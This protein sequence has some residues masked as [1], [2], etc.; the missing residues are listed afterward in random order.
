MK[1]DRRGFIRSGG[2]ALAA[3]GIIPA[4]LHACRTEKNESVFSD[5]TAGLEALT[6]DDYLARQEKARVVMRE[7]GVDALWI[8]GGI[9]MQ[10]YFDMRWWMSE[11]VFGAVLPAGGEP[12]WICPGF[13]GPRAEEVISFGEDIRTWEEHESPYTLLDEIFSSLSARKIALDP[14]VRSFVIQGIRRE[15]GVELIDGSSIINGCRGF[16]TDK[17]LA[18]MDLANNITKK[19][20]QWAFSQI[21][22]GMKPS[23]LRSLIAEGHN[24]LGTSGG[25]MALFGSQSAFP[26]GSRVENEL[27]DG[28][29]ILVDG[30]CTVEGYRSDVT[31]TIVCG[32]PNDKQKKV[33]E[34][35][36]KAQATAFEAIRP[37]VP[38]GELDRI[39]RQVIED[40]G[41]GP[42]YSYFVHRL[43]H[44]IGMEGHEWPYLVKDNPLPLQPGMTFS[45]EPGIYIYGEFG[46]RIEDCFVVT[47][48]G[49]KYLGGMLCNSLENPFGTA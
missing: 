13:E 4:F 39:A 21:Q 30:G 29:I 14:N 10:Y 47:E 18:Y 37:G 35:V 32:T 17:E 33:F 11:R 36:H 43:G 34:I 25:G 28:D 2:L 41:Y 24:Q 46:I 20:Y 15:S 19:A 7:K 42:Q 9:N 16:K 40:E 48:E 27:K 23:E 12:V 45:N 5:M 8:E 49:G 31:R 26:H 1:Q 6:D 22:P 38:A 44:G 3:T